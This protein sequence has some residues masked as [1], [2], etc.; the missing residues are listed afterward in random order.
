MNVPSDDAFRRSVERQI[1]INRT[2]TPTERFLALCELLDTLR[3]MAPRDP[4]ACERRLRVQ[5]ARTRE[6]EQ[7]RETFR[8]LIAGRRDD[9]AG[10]V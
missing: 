5:A 10:G 1:E 4:A 3:E 7:L 2:R 8:Q 6:R 9:A